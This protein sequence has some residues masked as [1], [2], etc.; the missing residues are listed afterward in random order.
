MYEQGQ[1]LVYTREPAP[2]SYSSGLAH[3]VH[4]AY[5]RDGKDFQALNQ[6]YGI[7]FARAVIDERDVIKPKGLKC[8]SIFA[9]A[10]G[11]FGII[12]IRTNLDGSCDDDDQGKVLL[13]T[14]KDLVTFEEQA[15]LQ[16]T[17]TSRVAE[18]YCQYRQEQGK[19]EIVWRDGEGNCYKNFLS[20]LS[21]QTS[22][23]AAQPLDKDCL[24]CK[25][26]WDELALPQGAVAGNIIPISAQLGEKLLLEWLPLQNTAI[27]VP[28]LFEAE[29]AEQVKAVQATAIYSDGSNVKKRVNWQ[30]DNI[31]FSKPGTYRVYGTVQQEQYQFP[32]AVGYADPVIIKWEG[33]YYFVATNDNVNNIGI[34]VRESPTVAGLFAQDFN[35]RLILDKDESRGLIQTFWAPEFHIVNGEMHIFFAVSGKQWGPQCHVMKLKAGGKITDPNS[36]HDP[37]AAVR[38]DGS[39][40]ATD[41]I[42]LDMT[43][44]EQGD[45]SYVSWSYRRNIGRPDDTGSMLYI[46]SVDRERPWQL[47]SDPVLLARPLYG[48]E[49]MEGTI[50]NEGSYPLITHDRVY[51][52]Y[53]G[54]AANGYSYAIG[55]L[56]AEKGSDLLDISNWRKRPTPALSY[57]SVE[58]EYGPGHNAFYVN[59]HGDTM[60]TYHALPTREGSPRCTAVRRVHFDVNNK[61]RL[62]MCPK[63]DLNSELAS[64]TMAVVVK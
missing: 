2:K 58:G 45:E 30:L 16:L 3:S 14:S 63:R 53:S 47:T 48:W 24:L 15:M 23:S 44:F 11:G 38:K 13:W 43:Y 59:E 37:V 34:F 22:L 4:L 57:Y 1:L 50:N 17:D 27:E 56:Y 21:A 60:L 6:N 20:E 29:C 25:C 19:Y 31:D 54:G 33:Q 32:L 9:T 61:P 28:E 64:V 46:A 42:T 39:P 40:L 36:W 7:L 55:L 51:I 41:G 35:E 18:A 62:D 26:D 52:A 12:A 5:S 10:D 8:P 49:N